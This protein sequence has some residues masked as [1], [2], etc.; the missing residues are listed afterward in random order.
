MELPTAC[1]RNTVVCASFWRRSPS[2]REF[3]TAHVK[4]TE[5]AVTMWPEYRRGEINNLLKNNHRHSVINHTTDQSQR[6]SLHTQPSRFEP[7]TC[8]WKRKHT[9]RHLA[10][11]CS[12]RL[13]H[14]EK[15]QRTRKSVL[16]GRTSDRLKLTASAVRCQHVERDLLVLC[17]KLTTLKLPYLTF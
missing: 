9:E 1:K 5:Q 16:S 15:V 7:G 6:P 2:S 10:C 13:K 17:I 8:V 14:R 3:K 11:R 4:L 12:S